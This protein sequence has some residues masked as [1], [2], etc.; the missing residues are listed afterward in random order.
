VSIHGLANNFK[1]NQFTTSFSEE[2]LISA[3]PIDWKASIPFKTF[4]AHKE[5][6]HKHP[7]SSSDGKMRRVI[8]QPQLNKVNKERDHEARGTLEMQALLLQELAR[9]ENAAKGLVWQHGRRQKEMGMGW[10]RCSPA[11]SVDAATDIDIWK[12]DMAQALYSIWGRQG[13]STS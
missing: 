5:N 9:Q 4:I 10:A 8:V 3:M 11:P 12:R 6:R 1:S 2:Q 7:A 13:S